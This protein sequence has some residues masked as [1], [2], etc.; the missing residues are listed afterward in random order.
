MH[1]ELGRYLF[2]VFLEKKSN[3]HL[4]KIH[5]SLTNRLPHLP[6]NPMVTFKKITG[7]RIRDIGEN[8]GFPVM[9]YQN[10]YILHIIRRQVQ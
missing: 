3:R 10:A 6:L 9:Y 5:L 2:Q 7:N 1:K 4:K 8:S